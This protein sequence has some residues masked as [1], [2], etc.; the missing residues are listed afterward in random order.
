MVK[1]ALTADKIISEKQAKTVLKEV[2]REKDSAVA[3]E[4]NLKFATDYYLFAIAYYTG[5]RV[6]ELAALKWGDIFEDNLIVRNGKGGKARTVIFG[7]QTAKLFSD[8]EQ[9]QKTTLKRLCR[10]GDS[11][12]MGQRGQLTRIGLHT[13][14]KYWVKRLSL[15]DSL[16]FHSWR[17]GAATRWLDS[18]IPLTSVRDQLGHSSIS[19][20]SSYLWFTAE[21]KEKLKAI[22]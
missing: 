18:G 12:F 2:G 19:T 11:I 20:T 10:Q 1:T 9:F 8:F 5:L 14:M 22:S 16:S 3:T 7:K 4:T 21:A 17:H 6:S 13:R 15:P